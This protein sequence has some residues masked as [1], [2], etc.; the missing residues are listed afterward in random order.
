[1]YN[2]QLQLTYHQTGADM[3]AAQRGSYD[4][5]NYFKDQI[6]MLD[7]G[8]QLKPLVVYERFILNQQQELLA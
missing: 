2:H 5:K 6:K 4:V 3:R 1:M 7:L 8:N